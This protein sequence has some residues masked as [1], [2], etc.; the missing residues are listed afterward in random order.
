LDVS[1][2]KAAD[3]IDY[4][5]LGPLEVSADGRAVEIGGLKQRALLAILLLRANQSVPRDVLVR[6]LW[7]EQPPAGAR[8]SLE[9]CVSRLRKTLDAAAAGPVLVTRPG[10]YRLQ[11]ADG[12]LDVTRFERLVA[13]GRRALG[14]NAPEQAAASFRGALALWR[15]QPLA[16]LS[17][18]PFAHAEI[19]RL[20]ELRLGAIEDRNESELALGHH[21]DIVSELQALV[22]LHPLRERPHEQLMIALY[23]SG[24]QAEALGVYRAARRNLV[25]DLGLEPGR[26][27]QRLEHAILRHDASLD[28]PD[29]GGAGQAPAPAQGEVLP[30]LIGADRRKPLVAGPVRVLFE[31]AARGRAPA[32]EVLA[33]RDGA[34]PGASA[35]AATRTLPRDIASFTGREAELAQLTGT[36]TGAQ[37]GGEVVGIHAIGGM[38]GIGKTTFAVHA[39]HRLAPGFPDGQIFLPLHAHTPGQRPVDPADALASL[40]LTAGLGAQ[41]IPPGLEA[42]AARWRDYVAGKKILLVLDDAAGHEHV[43]PLLPGIAGSLVLI[44][45][46]RRLTALEDAAA[47]SLDTLPPGEA[48][49]LLTRLAG[50]PDLGSGDDLAGEITRLCGYLP[51]AIG[52]LAR[53]LS[54]HPA[55]TAASLAAD[56]AAARNRLELMH[57]ENLSVAAAFDLSYHDLTGGQQRLF[58]R[59][60]V[61]PGPSIDAYAAA[62]LDGVSVEQ[63]RRHLEG[64]YDQHLLTEPAHGRYRLHDL[65][66]EHARALAAAG[67]PADCDAAAGRLLDY[68]LH[69]ALAA[70]RHVA[71]RAL[72]I[73]RPPPGRPPAWAPQLSTPGQAAAWLDAERPNLHA[74]AGCA[75]ARARPRHAVAIPAAMS[76]FLRAH[77]HWDQ[78]TAL[79]QAA[80]TTARQ[81]GDRPGQAGALV[82][83][84]VLGWLAGNYPAAAASLAR[85][86]AL[87][88]DLGDRLGQAYALN[89]L[90][91]VQQLTGDYPA[92]A[93]SLTRALGMFRGLGH[94]PG[95]A[96]A[97]NDLGLVQQLSGDYP[98]AAASLTQALGMFRDVGDQLGEAYALANLG[99]VQGLTGDYPGAAANQQQA[100]GMFRDVGNRPGQ[101]GALYDLGFVQQLAGDL[102]AAVASHQQALE[103]CRGLGERLGQAE[104]LNG[105]GELLCQ[106]SASHQA[107]DHHARA[108]AIARDISAPREEARALE[109]IGQCHLRH[110][111]PG[112]G[113]THLQQALTIYQRIAAPGARRVQDALRVHETAPPPRP[114][115]SILGRQPGAPAAP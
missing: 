101:A 58:R 105:L 38:A 74:V 57:A 91:I 83:L 42:R 53:Q 23:R 90:G 89:H 69:T 26:A 80:L 37:A 78:G 72:A 65:L 112:E 48:T 97:L 6:E 19:A 12:Q 102:A 76:G 28:L 2:D 9:V 36:V 75:A 86:L 96:F 67:D 18:E 3:M 60:G 99:L 61:H 98:A 33:A 56:L 87:Y 55:W 44:T 14:A 45:S 88:R 79:H 43:R 84:G 110:G 59:L 46:R 49:A 100:L 40:L 20:E 82:E 66:R 10:A 68:Y 77:G 63:T 35:A 39:A 27:L 64:L 52:M 113:A 47:I 50:R 17:D 73:G 31:A 81:A 94:R 54:H 92:A 29:R 109:G 25:E 32:A 85:A 11:V 71:A 21:A 107:R 41:Q 103:L 93:A 108:L 13:D 8:H 22:A 104:A 30:S 106:S 70:S 115:P 7:G 51:L 24:R 114:P 15:G 1:G 95:Q 5:I 4:R 34:P 111:N 16:D 62:A